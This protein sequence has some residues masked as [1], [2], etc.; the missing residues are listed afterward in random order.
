[1]SKITKLCLNLSKLCLKYVDSFSGHG[2]HI[3]D[4]VNFNMK[5]QTTAPQSCMQTAYLQ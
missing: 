4:Q 1:M 3:R 2:V 5:P